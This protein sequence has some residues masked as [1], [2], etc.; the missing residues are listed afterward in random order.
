M[1]PGIALHAELRAHNGPAI[2]E[3]EIAPL[4]HGEHRS[5]VLA[6]NRQP[7]KLRVHVVDPDQR[8]VAGAEIYLLDPEGGGRHFGNTDEHGDLVLESIYAD[9]FGLR[10]TANDFPE[11]KLYRVAVPPEEIQIVLERPRALEIELVH[12][13]G[14]P[15]EGEVKVSAG[16]QGGSSKLPGH[17]IVENLPGGEVEIQVQSEFGSFGRV[18]DMSIPFRRL[19]VGEKGEINADATIP[20]D[21]VHT[22]W[23][24]AIRMEHSSSVEARFE[25][26]D[27]RGHGCGG[28]PFGKYELCLEAREP[29]PPWAWIRIGAPTRITLDAQH[30]MARVEVHP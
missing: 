23:S 11:Q 9:P 15:V 2:A 3:V 5:V 25:A 16:N 28:F 26:L 10:I 8:A 18:H 22:D 29:A 13:D 30:P 12:S 19:V 7:K 17:W 27:G 4:A 20:D 24:V 14:S 21:H 1:R 6:M